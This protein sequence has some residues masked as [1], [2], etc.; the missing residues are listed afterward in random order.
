MGLKHKTF[1]AEIYE[2]D[3]IMQTV[4]CYVD[5][6]YED[7]SADVRIGLPLYVKPSDLINDVR[8]WLDDE[9]GMKLAKL[10][11]EMAPQTYA[12]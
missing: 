12:P 5:N 1:V 2:T 6:Y 10:T 11:Y 7:G 3:Q 8:F 9:C 4:I